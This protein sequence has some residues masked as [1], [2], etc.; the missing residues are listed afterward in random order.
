MTDREQGKAWIHYERG[1]EAGAAAR[2]A[3]REN[4]S[5]EDAVTPTG[6]PTAFHFE[7]FVFCQ[8]CE[9]ALQGKNTSRTSFFPFLIYKR[10]YI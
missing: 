4:C 2:C 5:A 10:I 8:V 3:R 9:S 6:Y 7:S 1:G